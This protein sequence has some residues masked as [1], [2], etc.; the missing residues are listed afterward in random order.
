MAGS[1]PPITTWWTTG[2]TS[3]VRV[4]SPEPFS[5]SHNMKIA[6][7]EHQGNRKIA[8]ANGDEHW[9]DLT[10]ASAALAPDRKPADSIQELLDSGRFGDYPFRSLYQA[11]RR[12]PQLEL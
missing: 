8:I 10:A 2:T 12:M 5:A 1:S 4:L 9:L 3:A 6:N 7:I 11:A